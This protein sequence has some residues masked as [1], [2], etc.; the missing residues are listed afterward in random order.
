MKCA[1]A[2][3]YIVGLKAECPFGSPGVD[4]NGKDKA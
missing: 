4:A 2:L 1:M 3:I